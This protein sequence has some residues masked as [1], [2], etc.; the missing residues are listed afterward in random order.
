MSKRITVLLAGL[1]AVVGV[2]AAVALAKPSMTSMGFKANLDT[3]QEVPKESGAKITAG[4][5]FTATISG[6]KMTWKLTFKNLTGPA[7]A[8][9]VHSGA[10]GKAGPVIVALCGPCTSPASGTAHISA[11]ISKMLQGGNT[12]VNVHTT[13]NPGGEI[14]GQVKSTGM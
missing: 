14:R 3:R 12:Y 4:G 5:S 13:K 7:T 1:V 8:A 2:V 6:T 11:A 9:H 10:K